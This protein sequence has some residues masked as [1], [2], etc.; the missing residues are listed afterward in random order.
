METIEYNKSKLKLLKKAYNEAVNQ[1][2]DSFTFQNQEY[3]TD[4]AK[5][6]IEHL[7]NSM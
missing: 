1:K 4:Y 6:L 5:Y 2:K 3:V 7:N